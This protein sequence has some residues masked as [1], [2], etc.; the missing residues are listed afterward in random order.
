MTRSIG[1]R[2]SDSSPVSTVANGWPA[3][4]PTRS[5]A[6]VPEFPQSTTSPGSVRPSNPAPWITKCPG[7]FRV[8]SRAERR[9]CPECPQTVLPLE[10][11]LDLGETI[12]E[13][14]QECGPM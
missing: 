6:V 8:T 3:S 5:R 9:N 2:R 7:P 13:R 10:E 4:T 12:G 1:R 14:P 11:P